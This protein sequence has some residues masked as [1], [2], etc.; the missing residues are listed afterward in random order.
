MTHTSAGKGYHVPLA[1]DSD[2]DSDLPDSLLESDP[3]SSSAKTTPEQPKSKPGSQK[4][5]IILDENHAPPHSSIAVPR[6]DVASGS[7][8]THRQP[9]VV[10]DAGHRKERKIETVV[11]DT[12]DDSSDSESYVDH[13]II[14]SQILNK[15]DE[16]AESSASL[17]NIV[18]REDNERASTHLDPVHRGP[19]SSIHESDLSDDYDDD[20]VDLFMDDGPEDLSS[21]RRSSPELGGQKD[22]QPGKAGT[23]IAETCPKPSQH[24]STVSQKMGTDFDA[25]SPSFTAPKPRYDPVRGSNLPIPIPSTSTNPS[26]ATGASKSTWRHTYDS[27][28]NHLRE[29]YAN[30]DQLRSSRWDVGPGAS[31]YVLSSAQ[32]SPDSP[33]MTADNPYKWDFV[34]ADRTVDICDGPSDIDYST[35]FNTRQ[36]YRFD[37]DG[38]IT[39][40]NDPPPYKQQHKPAAPV[41]ASRTTMRLAQI[42]TSHSATKTQMSIPNLVDD[43]VK[44]IKEAT[45]MAQHVQREARGLLKARLSGGTSKRKADDISRIDSAILGEGKV[46]ISLS[47]TPHDDANATT[48]EPVATPAKD[49]RAPK[50]V[51]RNDHTRKAQKSSLSWEMTKLGAAAATGGVGLMAFLLSPLA[52]RVLAWTATG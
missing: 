1:S 30:A 40:S 16:Q 35:N 2:D 4:D 13:V 36:V 47:S 32:K 27:F 44:Q 14:P 23:E 12:Y 18:S 21:K 51:K 10:V 6:S 52:D 9:S 28:S 15:D 49:E 31:S 48:P 26:A 11:H 33:A 22:S 19:F 3:P 38:R 43:T 34:G 29:G 37:A 25:S 24:H 45:E 7:Q 39:E 50:R 20:S 5:P 17:K 8:T 42:P 41:R 46:T